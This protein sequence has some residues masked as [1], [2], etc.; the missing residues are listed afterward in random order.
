MVLRC[1]NS[2]A[3]PCA[4]DSARVAASHGSA[5]SGGGS[6][7]GS[8]P[9]S[10]CATG[11][12]RSRYDS[13]PPS[14]GRSLVGSIDPRWLARTNSSPAGNAGT[15]SRQ[16][17]SSRRSTNHTDSSTLGSD[18]PGGCTSRVAPRFCARH[19]GGGV[20]V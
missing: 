6:D 13:R 4:R 1:S 8:G 2:A 17:C 18:R 10:R 11:D 3:T 5:P 16:P 9:R 12:S 14:R 7:T 20:G 19:E 15:A